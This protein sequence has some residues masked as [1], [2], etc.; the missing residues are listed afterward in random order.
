MLK[1][2]PCIIIKCNAAAQSGQSFVSVVPERA[3]SPLSMLTLCSL[4]GNRDPQINLAEAVGGVIMKQLISTARIS[5]PSSRAGYKVCQ[6]SPF[7]KQNLHA[8]SLL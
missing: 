7:P 5:T 3:N 4:A 8:P 2:G 6:L 1:V